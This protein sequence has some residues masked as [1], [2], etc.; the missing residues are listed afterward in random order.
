VSFTCTDQCQWLWLHSSVTCASNGWNRK[1]YICMCSHLIRLRLF[2]YEM[3]GKQ[4]TKNMRKKRTTRRFTSRMFRLCAPH[5]GSV[6]NSLYHV[7]FTSVFLVHFISAVTLIPKVPLLLPPVWRTLCMRDCW[8]TVVHTHAC[9]WRDQILF[10]RWWSKSV[11]NL[12][13]SSWQTAKL[14]PARIWFLLWW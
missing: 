8:K 1:L 7:H 12:Q 5:T 14:W 4:T 3:C 13:R 10:L 6:W 9:M 11:I 2:D